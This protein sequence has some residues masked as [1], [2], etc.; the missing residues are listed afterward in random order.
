M[1]TNETSEI[2]AGPWC[3]GGEP[4]GGGMRP[5]TL[6]PNVG[7]P[8]TQHLEGRQPSPE[9]ELM[10]SLGQI[11]ARIEETVPLLSTLPIFCVTSSFMETASGTPT[12]IIV[13]WTDYQ[14]VQL[15]AIRHRSLNHTPA[16][17]TL[18]P[19]LNTPHCH[20]HEQDSQV[21]KTESTVNN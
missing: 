12:Q 4:K 2:M 5:A 1:F 14:S 9:E 13:S 3:W 20:S 16:P 17:P 11:L 21:L 19:S 8:G 7:P 6:E 10:N 18:Q 15:M